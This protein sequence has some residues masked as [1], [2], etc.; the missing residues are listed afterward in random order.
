MFYFFIEKS[1]SA[2]LHDLGTGCIKYYVS[3]CS[4][5]SRRYVGICDSTRKVDES[6]PTISVPSGVCVPVEFL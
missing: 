6:M 4:G 1:A 3:Y 2:S 5:L